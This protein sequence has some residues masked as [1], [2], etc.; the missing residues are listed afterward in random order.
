M[1]LGHI[2]LWF[3]CA[4]GSLCI[5]S[6][7]GRVLFVDIEFF[8]QIGEVSR[9]DFLDFPMVFAILVCS[10]DLLGRLLC[11]LSGRGVLLHVRSRLIWY[12]D[13]CGRGLKGLLLGSKVGCMWVLYR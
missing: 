9:F 2:G 4:T 8:L 13:L 1:G 12:S 5:F 6:L 3:S 7:L 11:P 10:G